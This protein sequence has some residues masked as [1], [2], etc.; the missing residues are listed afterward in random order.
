VPRPAPPPASES[1][2]PL[3]YPRPQFRRDEWLSLNGEWDFAIDADGR[4]R[5]A[6]Q[7]RFKQSILVPFAPETPA[8]GIEE[9][10]FFQ[11]C[12]YR[13]T[14][15]TPKLGPNDRLILHF[16]AVDYVAT[17]WINGQPAIQHEGGY[18]PFQAD[19]TDLLISGKSQT[20]V[21][22]AEDDPHDLGKPRGKQDWKPQPHSIWYYRTSGIW[23]SV[24]TEVVNAA[25]I[26][27]VGWRPNVRRWQIAL[28]ARIADATDGLRLRVALSSRGRNLVEDEYTVTNGQVQRAIQL[29]DPGIDDA[30]NDLLWSP[31][32]PNLIDAKL[33][34]IDARGKVLDRVTSY[35]AMR[36]V[37]VSSDRFI[38]NSRPV[39]LQ[40]VLNQGYWP[41]G[42]LT[43]PSD[44]AYRQDVELIKSMGFNGCRMHQKIENPRFL[45]WADKLG[46]FVW[47]EMPSVYTFNEQSMRRLARQWADAIER[48]ASHPCI[49]AWVPFNE[50][51]G[52]PDLPIS[53]QQRH[54]VQAMYHLTKTLDPTRPVIGNDGW[55][56]AATDIIAIHDYEADASRLVARY[57]TQE[58]AVA[59]LLGNERPGNKAL[60]LQGFEYSGQPIMLTEFG[61]VAFSKDQNGTWGYS[62]ARTSEEL[63]MRYAQLLAAVR[64]LP[65]F[66][67]FA[68]TQFTDTYQEANGLLYMDRTPKFA[69]EEIACA[70][71]GPQNEADHQIEAKWR[72]R[73]VSLQESAIRG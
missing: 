34:L 70:T 42:G 64:A 29:P 45:Y 3:G 54:A 47:E 18:T 69:V 11:A 26:T 1:H 9:F 49:V 35:A 37:H 66:A 52:V 48:D 40:M 15:A 17:V 46:L 43:A 14:F 39:Q 50:S 23:Q 71:R 20:V 5:S 7:I 44:D 25:H 55:E 24:W 30:R 16:G 33:E 19:I 6:D 8:S 63:A 67:G 62:R 2:D 56:S 58:G 65:L 60:L 59:R 4:A 38:L 36:S 22:R 21:V 57:R 31:W 28:S 73:L 72:E 32:S 27:S 41:Q 68:Y 13:R 61:G 10:G 51:W 12:W 53:A